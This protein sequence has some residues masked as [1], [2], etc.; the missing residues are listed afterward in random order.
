M[1]RFPMATHLQLPHVLE[2]LLAI[3]SD[4]ADVPLLLINVL[5]RTSR[6]HVAPGVL[7]LSLHPGRLLGG[8]ESDHTS[9]GVTVRLVGMCSRVSVIIVPLLG[10]IIVPILLGLCVGRARGQRV[11]GARGQGR[12]RLQWFRFLNYRWVHW[13]WHG[14]PRRHVVLLLFAG[15]L[16]HGVL[17]RRLVDVVVVG[18]VGASFLDDLLAVGSTQH[19][20]LRGLELR[21]APVLTAQARNPRL[22]VVAVDYGCLSGTSQ[23]GDGL[24]GKAQSRRGLLRVGETLGR[25]EEGILSNTILGGIFLVVVLVGNHFDSRFRRGDCLF[26]KAVGGYAMISVGTSGGS[27]VAQI[28]ECRSLGISLKR[29]DDRIL[30]LGELDVQVLGLLRDR[31]HGLVL[32]A[33]RLCCWEDPQRALWLQGK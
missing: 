28:S 10:L 7:Q 8:I 3:L 16:L 19:W 12:G 27:S 31:V 22:R 1:Q 17:I 9:G 14:H 18:V 20:R 15:L 2:D 24:G 13:A 21:L 5:L 29:A 32:I 33:M 11:H 26:G 25:A 30:R 4:H 6:I 23:L